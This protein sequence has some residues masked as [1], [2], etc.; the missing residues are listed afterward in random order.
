MSVIFLHNCSWEMKSICSWVDW[1]HADT[2]KFIIRTTRVSKSFHLKRYIHSCE[3]RVS[4]RKKINARCGF[5]CLSLW[6]LQ[7]KGDFV[8]YVEENQQQKCRFSSDVNVFYQ[9]HCICKG[10]IPRKQS[11]T[12]ALVNVDRVTFVRSPGKLTRQAVQQ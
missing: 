5:T 10:I 12:D 7:C 4:G 8:W 2:I 3:N 9:T 11:V 6:L 1:G